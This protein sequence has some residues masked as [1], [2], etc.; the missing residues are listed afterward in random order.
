MRG[1]TNKSFGI[2]VAKLAGLPQ[3]VIS[4]AKAVSKELETDAQKSKIAKTESRVPDMVD[5]MEQNS[6]VSE[7]RTLDV[8]NMSPLQA[9]TLLSELVK[10]SLK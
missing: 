1:G 6:I 3:K 7:L 2:E 5:M 4:R 8:D 9:L 10:K